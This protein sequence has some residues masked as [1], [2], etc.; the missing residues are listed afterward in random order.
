MMNVPIQSRSVIRGIPSGAPVAPL[1]GV[2]ASCS[3]GHQI[4]CCAIVAG[5]VASCAAIPLGIPA[6][7]GAIGGFIADDCWQC[8]CGEPL[9]ATVCGWIGIINSISPGTITVPAFCQN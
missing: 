9:Q 2:E 6:C 4:A 8:D 1:T 7:A 3:I 5:M